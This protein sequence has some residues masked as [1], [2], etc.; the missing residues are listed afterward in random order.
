MSDEWQYQVR[1]TLA[2]E[3]AEMARHDPNDPLLGPLSTILAAH[4]A[5]LKCQYDAFADYVAEAEQRGTS[6]YPLHAWTKATIADPAKKAKYLKSFT[7]YVDGEEVYAREKADKL[8]QAL[9]PLVGGSLVTH[10][11][12]HDT[13]PANNPQPPKRYRQ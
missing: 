3:A 13:N 10:L 9:Q 8:E 12:K 1:L 7:L 2:D 5:T 11:A 6:A 4:G